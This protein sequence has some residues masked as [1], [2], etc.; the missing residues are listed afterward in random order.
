VGFVVNKVALGQVF[1]RVR[2]FS[3]VNF[4]PPAFH[5]KEKR[6]KLIMFI[7][8][9][10]ASVA[11]AARPFTIKQNKKITDLATGKVSGQQQS[12]LFV[13]YVVDVR[14][15]ENDLLS[16]FS[17]IN[18]LHHIFYG[19]KY[20]APR[21]ELRPN[22]FNI[23]RSFFNGSTIPWG[24]RPHHFSTLHDHTLYTHHVR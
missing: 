7:T 24:P 5:Y 1:L 23:I 18:N 2:R 4:I 20:F 11:S 6:K 21:H 19:P 13:Q 10:G 14:W 16:P 22:P 17:R 9:C 15:M 3:L 12:K 8:G